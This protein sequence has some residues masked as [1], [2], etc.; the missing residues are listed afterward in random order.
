M[1][2]RKRKFYYPWGL[3][4]Y[5]YHFLHFIDQFVHVSVYND[6]YYFS[7]SSNTDVSTSSSTNVSAAILNSAEN[8]N[9][10]LECNIVNLHVYIYD[11]S[12]SQC[13]LFMLKRFCYIY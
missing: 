7:A 10:D 6:L 3:I 11:I 8:V 5:L 12:I 13:I 2:E 4:A 9:Q 1:K